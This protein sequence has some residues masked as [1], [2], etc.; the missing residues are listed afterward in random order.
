MSLFSHI[1]IGQYYPGSSFLHRMDPRAKI[2]ALPLLI[3]M[4]LLADGPAG[5][6][7]A[8]GPVVLALLAAGIPPGHFWQGLRPLW[9]ILLIG[10]VIQGL[11]VPGAKLWQWGFISV[12]REGLSLGLL[13][14]YRLSLIIIS[15]MLLT[16]TTTPL[17]LTSALEKLL[18]PFKKAG[19][20]AHE[21]ALM[22]TIALR[23]IPTLLDEATLILKA[24]QARGG[25]LKRGSLTQRLQ[26][27]VAFLV[28]LLAGS[29]RRA[30][31]LATAMEARCYRGDIQ[32]TRLKQLRYR[33]ADI[34]A[35]AG[36]FVLTVA[37]AAA[38]WK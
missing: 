35:L 30:D 4:G 9:I 11:T 34:A 3:I 27:L 33:P 32:R 17:N 18:Q 5:Y 23:F 1:S 28:P 13:L 37:V 12:S 6:I 24:Q 31:E 26:A 36:L 16:M 10:L 22:M 7:M 25:S 19:V 38:R 20:P 2:L 29:L 14:F 8:G 15:T 21:L